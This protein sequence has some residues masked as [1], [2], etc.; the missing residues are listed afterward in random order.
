MMGM[1]RMGWAIAAIVLGM[2]MG[3]GAPTAAAQD[4][5]M[6]LADGT[7]VDL[8]RRLCR[9]NL[10]R[11]AIAPEGATGVLAFEELDLRP[12]VSATT[13]AIQGIIRNR[14]NGV[15]NLVAFGWI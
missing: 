7:R 15:V 14:S 13:A 2:G 12:Q 10:E 5:F 6:E 8:N 9:H 4:C 11:R 3:L 1:G